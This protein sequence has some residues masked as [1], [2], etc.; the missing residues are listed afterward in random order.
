MEA[1]FISLAFIAIAA[2]VC[3]LLAAL[4]PGKPI[5]ETVFLLVA[6]A[7]LGPYGLGLVLTGDN[8]SL[9][10]DLGL[11]FLFLLA[12]YEIN[13]ENLTGRQGKRGLATWI[14]T[15]CIALAVVLLLPIFMNRHIDGLAVG[16]ALTTTAVGTLLPI[17]EEREILDTPIGRSVLAYGT[18]GEL[19]PIFAIA[20]L[21]STRAKWLTILI[22]LVFIA[23][24]VVA[25]ILP[26]HARQAG[27]KLFDF[28]HRNS[29]TNA[30]MI[31]RAV[32]MLLIGLTAISA[33]FE[34]DI[35]LG[36]FA[37][38]F[39][40]RYIIPEGS[41][42]MESKLRTIGYGFFIPLF[43]IV[44]GAKIDISAVTNDPGLLL[45]FIALLLVIRALPIY[46]ALKTDKENHAMGPSSR[47]TVALYCTTA[48]PLIVAV[49][50]IAQDTGS[51]TPTT[52][53]TLVAAGGIT[54]LLMP[55]LA[56]LS[57]RTV[58]AEPIK[59]VK[60]IA[61]SPRRTPEILKAHHH[62]SKRRH[63]EL[64]RSSVTKADVMSKS[65]APVIA[66]DT[67]QADTAVSSIVKQPNDS[68]E[69]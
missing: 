1:A 38:G 51:M 57:L 21:L 40:L 3:P 60:E 32:L 11:G 50:S 29:D 52:A 58:N 5:S 41:K 8:M 25:A 59:A 34:L 69:H 16:I 46:I 14:I 33:I 67:I 12:G 44:S 43:F 20:L 47:L 63:Q 7:L 26:R 23:I 37:T 56:S 65:E 62:L 17:L 39:I 49:T 53:S 64:K 55:L 19:C 9:L 13:P 48:L 27:T 28:I 10:S 61:A 22:L 31:V 30:Q 45:E 68:E 18:W 54:V 2:F 66:E 24:A 42:T 36:A 6:G 4:I 35:V 15:F